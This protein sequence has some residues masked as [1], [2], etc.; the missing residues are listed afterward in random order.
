MTAIYTESSG[1]SEWIFIFLEH[2]VTIDTYPYNQS[3]PI[4]ICPCICVSL[5]E[6]F[7]YSELRESGENHKV[8]GLMVGFA[9][10]YFI[11]ESY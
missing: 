7:S 4:Y 10:E 5:K 3:L 11:L 2:L 8:F 9:D 1:D 6:D